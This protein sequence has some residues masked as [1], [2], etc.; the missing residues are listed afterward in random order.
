[1]AHLLLNMPAFCPRAKWEGE[2][3]PSSVQGPPPLLQVTSRVDVSRGEHAALRKNRGHFFFFL[4]QQFQFLEHQR[5]TAAAAAA[6]Q[7]LRPPPSSSQE[8]SRKQNP[9]TDILQIQMF[10]LKGNLKH[11]LN[12]FFYKI[13][14]VASLLMKLNLRWPREGHGNQTF[15]GLIPPPI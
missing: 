12:F 14:S 6:P 4:Q 2:W 8:R 11:C 5:D 7:V 9:Q 15:V 3:S 1:M 13:K 10:I